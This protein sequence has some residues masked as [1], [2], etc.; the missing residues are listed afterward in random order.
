[1]RSL[2]GQRRK[3]REAVDADFGQSAKRFKQKI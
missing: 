1:M 3:S 2:K